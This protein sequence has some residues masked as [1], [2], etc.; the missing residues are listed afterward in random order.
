MAL[1]KFAEFARA[2]EDGAE[3]TGLSWRELGDQL[4]AVAVCLNC[5]CKVQM[6]PDAVCALTDLL[7]RRAE[8]EPK[9]FARE[10]G[11]RWAWSS[12]IFGS[13]SQAAYRAMCSLFLA[14]RSAWVFDGYPDKSPWNIFD[15]T[16]AGANFRKANLAVTVED[17]PR[18]GERQW[19]LKTSQ[20]LDADLI[21]VNTKGLA[22]QFE[23]EP[24]ACVPGD[25]PFLSDPAAVHLV[26]SWS[27]TAPTARGTVGGRWLERG[28]YAYVG[29]V[30][31]PF[32]SAFVPTPVVAA[33]LVSTVPWGAVGRLDKG[34]A[35]KIAVFGDPLMTVGPPPPKAEGPALTGIHDLSEDVRDAVRKK[36]FELALRDLTVLGRD[37]DAAKLVAAL[38]RDDAASF[39]PPIA[40]A[41]IMPLFR[42]HDPLTLARVFSKLP[43]LADNA[44]DGALRDALWNACYLELGAAPDRAIIDALRANLRPDQ[45]ARDAIDLAPA[46]S[47]V[48]GRD[49]AAGLLRETQAGCP[50]ED[51]K[52]RLD[53]AIHK[54]AARA[55]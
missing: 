53:E 49:A 38:W 12:Q 34:P 37:A 28:A 41:A 18:Q 43:G 10:T 35:W 4:D 21:L 19:R 8:A 1:D 27:A 54:L 52:K 42:A 3:H 22:N 14:P 31:E 33:R 47:R 48:Q 16:A 17:T 51:D 46:M 9:V 2:V 32:L 5:P 44:P 15:G 29:S 20:G 45:L 13:Q 26:H 6:K 25:V 50:R 36:D 40:R 30:Q 39:T 23:L 24:G 55:P 11:A 7:G